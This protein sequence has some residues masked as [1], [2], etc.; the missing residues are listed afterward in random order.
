MLYTYRKAHISKQILYL[1]PIACTIHNASRHTWGANPENK[2]KVMRN[3]R[4]LKI[5]DR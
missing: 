4:R 2:G 1:Y 5:Q 3:V